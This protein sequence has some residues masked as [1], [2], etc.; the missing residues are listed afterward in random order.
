L[1]QQL[2]LPPEVIDDHNRDGRTIK[3]HR[4][5]IRE[6]LGFHP[7]TLA[8]QRALRAWLVEEVLPMNRRKAEKLLKSIDTH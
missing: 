1:A 5:Q 8:D 3:E 6:W 4:R 2:S 7:A